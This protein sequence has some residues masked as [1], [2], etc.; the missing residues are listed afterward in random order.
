MAMSVYKGF[1]SSR[2]EVMDDLKKTG[3]WPTTYVSEPSDELPMNNWGQCKN[4]IWL[5]WVRVVSSR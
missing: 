2:E 3:H 1:F 5:T 4:C